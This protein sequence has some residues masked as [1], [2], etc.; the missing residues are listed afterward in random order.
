MNAT[1]ATF[2]ML[3]AVFA[4]FAWVVYSVVK[5]ACRKR[6]SIFGASPALRFVICAALIATACFEIFQCMEAV[7]SGKIYVV[8][9][10]GF[11]TT[12]HGFTVYQ[13]S[14]PSGFWEAICSYCYLSLIFIYLFVAE[15]IIAVRQRKHVKLRPS[16]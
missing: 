10:G 14:N 16:A 4:L 2:S 1:I 8:L 11:H 6:R 15:I 3:A 13:A 7:G 12:S 9:G 5:R